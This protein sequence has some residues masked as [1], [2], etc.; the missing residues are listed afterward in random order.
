[1]TKEKARITYE[2]IADDGKDYV[3]VR[4]RIFLDGKDTE[5]DA[6]RDHTSVRTAYSGKRYGYDSSGA[7]TWEVEVPRKGGEYTYRTVSRMYARVDAVVDWLVYE[8]MSLAEAE[9][10]AG[11]KPFG[12]TRRQG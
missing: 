10:A 3:D 5:A 6:V 1:M 2:R 8:G 11:K 4:Y 7:D 12:A 9:A